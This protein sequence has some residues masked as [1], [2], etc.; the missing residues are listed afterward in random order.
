MYHIGLETSHPHTRAFYRNDQNILQLGDQPLTDYVKVIPVTS[1]G[2]L[3]REL[4]PP[5]NPE[6]WAYRGQADSD[7][8]LEPTLERL[9]RL[10]GVYQSQI[11]EY[12]CR[13]F[14]RRAYQYLQHLP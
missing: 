11:E 10:T 9:A 12:V 5:L 6:R 14:K 8:K 2:D 13:A 3:M 4:Q 1:V 7:W